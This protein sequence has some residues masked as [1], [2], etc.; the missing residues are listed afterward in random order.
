MNAISPLPLRDSLVDA[1]VEV[2]DV[3]KV[4]VDTTN[5]QHIIWYNKWK[6]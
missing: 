3:D 1:F 5:Y 2:V 6:F 4:V